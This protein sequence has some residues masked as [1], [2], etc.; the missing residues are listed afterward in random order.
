MENYTNNQLNAITEDTRTFHSLLGQSSKWVKKNLTLEEKDSMVTLLHETKSEVSVLKESVLTKPVFA[1][2]GIS[3]VGKSYL[4]KNLLSVDG[5]SLDIELP[6]NDKLD[7]LQSINPKGGGT[8]S[9]GV[10]SRFTIDATYS[11][12]DFPIQVKILDVKDLVLILC[13]SFFSDIMKLDYYPSIQDFNTHVDRFK[14]YAASSEGKQ[15]HLNEDHLFYLKRYF[16]TYLERI[17]PMASNVGK[18]QFWNGISDIIDRIDF[19]KWVALFEILWANDPHFSTLFEKLISGLKKLDFSNTIHVNKQAILRDEGKILDVVRVKGIFN[20]EEPTKIMLP[21]KELVDFDLYLLSALTAEISMPVNKEVA[22]HKEFLKNTDLLDFP[23]A[24]SRKPFEKEQIKQEMTPELFLR[25]KIS[26]LFNKYSSNYEINNLLFCIKNW[27]NEVKEIPLLINDWI[28]R[29]VGETSEKRE[30]RIGKNGTSPLFVVLTFYNQT[31]EYNSNSDQG[32][33]SEKWE[34]RFIRLFK[35]ETVT[36]A[37][38]WDENWTESEK[39]FK[40]FYPLRDLQ[41]STDIFDGYLTETQK[42]TGVRPDRLAYYDRLKSSF[43][44]FPYVK[45]H[46]QNPEEAWN[47]SSTPNQDGSDRIIR[48]LLPVANNLIKTN[49]YI[50]QLLDYKQIAVTSLKKHHKTDDINEQREKAIQEGIRI[51]N[52]LRELF[53][54]GSQFGEFLSKLYVSNTVVY[55][56]IHENYLPASNNH[57]PT[58]EEVIIRTYDLDLNKTIEENKEILRAHQ[59]LNSIEAVEQWLIDQQ[60]NLEKVLQNVHITAASTLVDG[61]ISIWK[62]RLEIANFKEYANQGLDLSVIQSINQNLLQTFEIFEVRRELIHLFEKK[63]R[64]L[65]VSNDTDE[66]LASII[67]SYINDFV[68]NYGFNF[69]KDE[70]RE[71]ILALANEKR[72]NTDTLMVTSRQINERNLCD[73]FEEED[74]SNQ[75][76]VTYPAINHYRSFVTKIQLILLSNCGFRT[77]NIEENKN[78]QLII[79]KLE[80]LSFDGSHSETLN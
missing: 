52:A 39:N 60:I 23:G 31:L 12:P 47:A 38:D 9:T 41:F 5:N 58:R 26:Y 20:S 55:N 78:L 29:N 48:D 7:F 42:E 8:E 53:D 27:N 51:Q 24:R 49:N 18:S 77:Y 74:S 70:R 75:L 61:V 22:N 63:T 73:L 2:F 34:K 3:Q 25:G 44:N 13:D 71:Q 35:E 16:E 37:N 30:K 57:N 69:I 19:S 45:D 33:L 36:K 28:K 6:G 43:V 62:N 72:I 64:M 4:V 50:N 40:S 10:V 68:S 17:N 76:N 54:S 21:N 67:T 32:D 14:E 11:N 56:Y 66:Y 80:G 79:D 46:F 59:Q 15:V 65:K 1:L